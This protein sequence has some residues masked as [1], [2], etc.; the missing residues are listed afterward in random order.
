MDT[1]R[2]SSRMIGIKGARGVGK[3]TLLLQYIKLHLMEE[4]QYTLYVNLDNIYFYNHTVLDLADQF[5]KAGGKYLFLDEVHKYPDWAVEIKNIYDL[6]PKMHIVFTGSSML[7]IINAKADLSRRVI[8]YTMQG[9]SFREYLSIKIGQNLPI[10]TLD[11]IL[12]YHT[13]LTLDITSIV[14]PLSHFQNYLVSGYYP[15]FIEDELGYVSKIQQVI[16]L[17]IEIELPQ[18][19]GVKVSS[20]H[21]LKQLLSIIAQSVPMTPNVSKISSHI[22]I[23]RDTV[24]HYL[25]Y[26]QEAGIVQLIYYNNDHLSSLQ[27]P[28]KLLIE[29]TNIQ[30]ALAA[31]NMN[32]GSMREIFFTNQTRVKHQINL[33]SF[34]DYTLDNKYHFEVGGKGK[35]KKQL[36]DNKNTYI[37]RDDTEHGAGNAIP[38]WAF[39]FLY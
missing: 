4:L 37:V 10:W 32:I 34:V 5:H 11:D 13:R 16:Q 17:S 33:S 20:I 27:K 28:D 6:Y 15:F 8:I 2:W 29:N 25:Y 30:Y 24:V 12:N 38:L 19:R 26:L 9:L 14:S 3:S 35:D 31:S 23:N 39:G 1:I 36:K 21:H 7:E 22:G 18:L